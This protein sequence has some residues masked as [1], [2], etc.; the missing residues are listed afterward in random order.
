M[1]RP[2]PGL[3][4]AETS[5]SNAPGGCVRLPVPDRPVDHLVLLH[6]G[7]G[8]PAYPVQ[9]RTLACRYS[10]RAFRYHGDEEEVVRGGGHVRWKASS[11]SLDSAW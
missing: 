11:P 9:S 8:V 4:R 6:G 10:M 1:S 7:L 3:A 5:R 2:W